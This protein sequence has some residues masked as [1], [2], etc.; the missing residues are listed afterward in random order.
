MPLWRW[1][2]QGCCLRRISLINFLEA[3]LTVL[4]VVRGVVEGVVES[5]MRALQSRQAMWQQLIDSEA[6]KYT[7][8]AMP[9][10][11]QEGLQPLQD[12]LVAIA[13]DQI[14]C[15]DDQEDQGQI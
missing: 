10:V 3:L 4:E 2:R 8:P 11:E 7:S 12:W 13:N 9:Q 1:W 5:M 14:A 15:I 6:Q